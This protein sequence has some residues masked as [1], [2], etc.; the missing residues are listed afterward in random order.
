MPFLASKR[1]FWP[2]TD[3]MRSEVKKIMPMFKLIEF[4]EINF[5][6]GCMI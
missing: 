4:S 3:F 2:L 6:V 5:S 1:C